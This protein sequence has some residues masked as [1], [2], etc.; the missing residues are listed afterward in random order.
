MIQTYLSS[1]SSEAGTYRIEKGRVSTWES[2]MCSLRLFVSV[3]LS[4][5]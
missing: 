1:E 2:M 4:L 3:K 5:Y